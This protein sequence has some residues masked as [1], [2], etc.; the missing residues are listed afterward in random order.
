REYLTSLRQRRQF[1]LAVVD[2]PTFSNSKRM[3]DDWDVQQDHADLLT[4]TL[5]VM[6]P[7]GKVFFSTNSRRFKFDESSLKGAT[8]REITKHTIPEDFRN[9]RIHRCWRIVKQSADAAP[10]G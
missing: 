4:A 9:K 3:D 1:D 2:P 10:D 5:A 6:K 7:D 8:V